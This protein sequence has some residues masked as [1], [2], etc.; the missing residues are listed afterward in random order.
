MVLHRKMLSVLSFLCT[1]LFATI[2]IYWFSF[3]RMPRGWIGYTNSQHRYSFTYPKKWIISD[4]GN[5]EI[6]VA[7]K[8][9]ERCYFPL[10]APEEYLNNLYFQVFL[11][12]HF[13]GSVHTG[14]D[15]PERLKKWNSVSWVLKEEFTMIGLPKNNQYIRIWANSV[16]VRPIATSSYS[17]YSGWKPTPNDVYEKQAIAYPHNWF[18]LGF[19]SR[20]S[21]SEELERVLRSV[22]FL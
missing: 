2:T 5:G 4:C 9:V 12:G 7:K 1:L 10:D 19:I 21:Y 22:R 8:P 15:V 14:L 6:V 16:P 13:S 17:L 3:I 18:S 20:P 11:P